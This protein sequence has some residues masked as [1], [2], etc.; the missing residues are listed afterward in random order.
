MIGKQT[1][2]AI[3]ETQS[4]ICFENS[5]FSQHNFRAV[6]DL[7]NSSHEPDIVMHDHVDGQNNNESWDDEPGSLVEA[8]M[9]VLTNSYVNFSIQNFC[10]N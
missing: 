10:R 1:K 3:T 5:G 8:A 7:Q 9:N 4:Y 2:I 6:E